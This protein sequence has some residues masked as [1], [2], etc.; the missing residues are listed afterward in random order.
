LESA[1]ACDSPAGFCRNWS[2]ERRHYANDSMAH[3]GEAV[4]DATAGAKMATLRDRFLSQLVKAGQLY[5]DIIFGSS[6]LFIVNSSN[7]SS[8]E[9]VDSSRH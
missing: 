6:M 5:F 9:C 4:I 1:E 7:T 2:L 3:T 8:G